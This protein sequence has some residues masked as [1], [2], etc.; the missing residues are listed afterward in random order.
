MVGP[1]VSML[2]GY[3]PWVWAW[4]VMASPRQASAHIS[5]LSADAGAKDGWVLSEEPK[6]KTPDRFRLR[7]FFPTVK[8]GVKTLQYRVLTVTSA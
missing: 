1:R 8:V 6:T 7:C 2:G 3:R 4:R 5:A